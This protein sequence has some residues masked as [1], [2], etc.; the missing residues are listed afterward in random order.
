[1]VVIGIISLVITLLDR[2][3]GLAAILLGQPFPE[4]F[5]AEAWQPWL[6]CRSVPVIMGGLG[7]IVCVFSLTARG[8]LAGL[9]FVTPVGL[10][11]AVPSILLLLSTLLRLRAFHEF[12]PRRRGP[13]PG[14][15]VPNIV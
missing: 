1:M 3:A 2:G 10:L 8:I 15:P 6:I 14:R 13:G 7:G 5:N 9:V 11:A 12:K 4:W